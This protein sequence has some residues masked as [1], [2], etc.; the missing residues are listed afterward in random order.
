MC[1]A[2][3]PPVKALSVA[4][5][6][7]VKEAVYGLPLIGTILFLSSQKLMEIETAPSS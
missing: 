5:A 7:E 6:F 4:L 1:L 2:I 3:A